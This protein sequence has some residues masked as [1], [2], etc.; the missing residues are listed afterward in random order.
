MVNMWN[1]FVILQ[2]LIFTLWT[3]KE[4]TPVNEVEAHMTA[5]ENNPIKL[6]I[7]YACR[8][9]SQFSSDENSTNSSNSKVKKKSKPMLH[10]FDIARKL[11]EIVRSTPSRHTTEHQNIFKFFFCFVVFLYIHAYVRANPHFCLDYF[12]YISGP[13]H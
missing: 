1:P 2:Q 10:V 7:N 5:S 3:V 13:M 12:F 8:H 9:Q 4:M 11:Y 6:K